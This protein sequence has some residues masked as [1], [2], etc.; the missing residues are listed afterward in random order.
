LQVLLH[1]E[2]LRDVGAGQAERLA[3][4]LQSRARH[5]LEI[6]VTP[7]QA[8]QPGVFELLGAPEAAE[9]V[10]LAGKQLFASADHRVHIEESAVRVEYD[11]LNFEHTP[12]LLSL[13]LPLH[14]NGAADLAG[15]V[16]RCAI[17]RVFRA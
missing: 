8:T 1:Q 4:E 2:R 10:A 13:K 11:C 15:A 17:V 6:F 12:P 14:C 9:R 7:H 5:L 3:S 16:P